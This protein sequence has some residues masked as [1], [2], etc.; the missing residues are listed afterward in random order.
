[1]DLAEKPHRHRQLGEP[2]QAVLHRAHVIHDLVDVS[3]AIRCQQLRLGGEQILQRAL[4]ALD[5]AREH[6]LLAHV[7]ENKEVRVGQRLH[8]AVE[9]AQRTV[10]VGEQ[11]LQ[12][13]GNPDRRV[14]RQRRR[15]ECA[16][17]FRLA[18]EPTG[19]AGIR[20]VP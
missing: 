11:A 10:G 9:P 17:A 18:H 8:G 16:V 15:Q 1:V 6:R 12:L 5:L 7:H 13:A 19:P 14:R 2:C 4:G 20:A 3:R